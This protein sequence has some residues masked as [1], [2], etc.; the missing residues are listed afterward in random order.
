MQD[1]RMVSEINE[2]APKVGG[3]FIPPDAVDEGIPAEARVVG[4]ETIVPDL[5]PKAIVASS[6][7]IPIESSRF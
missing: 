1:G 4:G 2:F 6:L 7:V 5:S 3:F